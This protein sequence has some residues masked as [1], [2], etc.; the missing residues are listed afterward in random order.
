MS[1]RMRLLLAAL[2]GLLLGISFQPSTLYTS[3]YVGLLPLLFMLET[4]KG[5]WQSLRYSYLAFFIFHCCI[6]YW[7]GGFV[8]AKD[9]W[10][11]AAGAAL[12]IF[13]PLFYV[14]VIAIYLLF[15]KRL[16]AILA[17]IGFPFLWTS[18][19]YSHSLGEFSFPWLT[20]GNSQAYDLYRSQ[21]IE[22]TSVYGLSFL[23]VLINAI[24]F[25]LILVLT[26][27]GWKWKSPIPIAMIV[28]L[29]ILYSIPYGY[30]FWKMQ[31][32]QSRRPNKQM[33]VAMI[34][35]NLDPWEK[36]GKDYSGRWNSYTMQLQ[37]YLQ[38]TKELA[39]SKPDLII[40][41]ETAIP[42]RILAPRYQQYY[43]YL[44]QSLDETGIPVFTG[45]AHTEFYDS[46]HA[47]LT[48]NRSIEPGVYYDDFNSTALLLPYAPV[49]QIYKKI[50]LVPYAERIPYAE[51]FRFLIEPLKWNVG[52]GMWGI[53]KDTIVFSMP[54]RNDS[55]RFAGIICYESVYPNFI[56]EFTKRGVQFLIVV[57]N[58][59]WWGNTSGAY[60][61]VSIA[62]LR[63]IENRRWILHCTNGG[64]SGFIDPSGRIHKATPL[65]TS[66]TLAQQ[67]SIEDELTFYA[68][69]GDLF[70]QTC[71]AVLLCMSIG[72]VAVNRKKG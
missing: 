16:G 32:V 67:I 9:P 29:F 61:H 19:E 46:S 33:T 56:R 6:V 10:M 53:G 59:S 60:Q 55:V 66:T 35:P 17:I 26:K 23:I 70:A 40:W 36:W 49:T 52:I 27:N 38:K 8:H 68:K 5:F 41:P 11:M 7:T 24:L 64:I 44:R 22:Y 47:P 28:V 4:S 43:Q 58:D 3:A 69:N 50:V 34:Q 51:S 71:V 42:F 12:L 18:Y 21:I 1:I 45:L 13:H 31:Q 15:R 65:F 62:S 20:L 30:G 37:T 14:A 57:S 63:A 2:S 39:A 25:L 72:A 54:L 48:A